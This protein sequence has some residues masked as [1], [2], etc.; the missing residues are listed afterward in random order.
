MPKNKEK[1]NTE[2]DLAQIPWDSLSPDQKKAMQSAGY[3]PEHMGSK[4]SDIS[5]E[6]RQVL[7]QDAGEV[8]VASTIKQRNET[9][10]YYADL[11]R[12]YDDLG[13]A[14]QDDYDNYVDS[15]LTRTRDYKASNSEIVQSSKDSSSKSIVDVN[16][17]LKYWES[18]KEANANTPGELINDNNTE[19]APANDVNVSE[20][21]P[22]QS[23]TSSAIEHVM[24]AA[25]VVGGKREFAQLP[26]EQR[27]EL[28]GKALA[29]EAERKRRGESVEG[30]YG[31]LNGTNYEA[32]RKNATG[33]DVVLYDA[34]EAAKDAIATPEITAGQT[35]G[36]ELV[37]YADNSKEVD[38]RSKGK[39][40]TLYGKS[41]E[42][43]P[44]D[45]L[46]EQAPQKVEDIFKDRP[47]LLRGVT[48]DRSKY[49][50]E[51]SFKAAQEKLMD[52]IHITDADRDE[53][54]RVK[55]FTRLN[56]MKNSLWMG[57]VM[58]GYYETKF[59]K[60][61]AE[62][63]RND[64]IESQLNAKEWLN[65]DSIK[66]P[67]D[68][69]R[70]VTMKRMILDAS[71]DSVRQ[72]E[73][74]EQLA[75]DSPARQAMLDL[76]KQFAVKGEDGKYM[77]P[78][79]FDE[80]KKRIYAEHADELFGD[81]GDKVAYID[82]YYA[83]AEM[84]RSTAD[85]EEGLAAIEKGFQMYRAKTRNDLNTEAHRTHVERAIEKW[86]HSKFGKFIPPEALAAAA[87]IAGYA[88]SSVVRSKAGQIISFG[89]GSLV[90]GVIGAVREGNAVKSER[91]TLNQQLASGEINTDDKLNQKIG[92]TV[93]QMASAKDM[94]NNAKK[95]IASGDE[96]AMMDALTEMTW[97]QKMGDQF[98]V[99]LI[100]YSSPDD[101]A[102]EGLD[103]ITSRAELIVAL[104]KANPDFDA[105]T[106]NGDITEK[107]GAIKSLNDKNL[108]ESEGL[109][110]H[111]KEI[112]SDIQAKD[113][114]FAKLKAKR[115]AIRGVGTVVSSA[116]I[117]SAV[118]E[119]SNFV[120]DQITP[121]TT[122]APRIV[123]GNKA[124]YDKLTEEQIAEF[125][126]KGATVDAIDKM[127]DKTSTE[128][129]SADQATANNPLFQ[130]TAWLNNN[131]ESFDRNELRGYLQDGKMLYQP[132]GASFTNGIH[133]EE[134]SILNAAQQG[135]IHLKLSPTEATQS[136]PF[137][138]VGKLVDGKI[139]F[140]AEPGSPAAKMLADGSYKFAE[141]TDN[142]GFV[143]ATDIGSGTAGS[144]DIAN[145]VQEKVTE[146]D[147]QFP[148]KT[149]MD[150]AS[151]AK[152]FDHV[153]F[154]MPVW[155][156]RNMHNARR[157]ESEAPSGNAEQSD[158]QPTEVI[159]PAAPE[160]PTTIPGS[161]KID[162]TPEQPT[163]SEGGSNEHASVNYDSTRESADLA[164][165]VRDTYDR[166]RAN[167][168][169][170]ANGEMHTDDFE[171]KGMKVTLEELG[172]DIEDELNRRAWNEGDK[173][174]A[175]S[176]GATKELFDMPDSGSKKLS[177]RGRRELEEFYRDSLVID[178][179]LDGFVDWYN[180]SHSNAE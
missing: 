2:Q 14:D 136:H 55:L 171:Y 75:E 20:V 77:T 60:Q 102:T 18:K 57:G 104:R 95:A 50:E 128:T 69:A 3:Q 81:K 9:A 126:S 97:R 88:T 72:G 172:A 131:T 89:G 144:F 147:V 115:Q 120:I 155:I 19:R 28:Q 154:P 21:K 25:G 173:W 133:I 64:D 42:I 33:Q 85:H 79:E 162:T 153:P 78:E 45:T 107:L 109:P 140:D 152:D 48:I 61:A 137:D 38:I 96:Q 34:N 44:A 62:Q 83:I 54:G 146:Y 130:R 43:E 35:H 41:K 22:Y 4:E 13:K 178:K 74:R 117:G 66:D 122:E 47:D 106:F 149:V 175:D 23:G 76:I 156:R 163:D 71:M 170:P 40:L 68:R 159:P 129:V 132:S 80:A 70:A 53:N 157:P 51:A 84:A 16:E 179:S 113:K 24:S 94:M 127:V 143:Y 125:K 86:E 30:F 99:D 5:P 1:V 87:G 92:E 31:K 121:D 168:S 110:D 46:A 100:S 139:E 151:T 98:H 141:I 180:K 142:N 148:D 32:D 67:M 161:H 138:V 49:I 93:Y 108:L 111:A 164:G 56:K 91:A 8:A 118:R 116:V 124:H 177:P 6:R 169:N 158:N 52:A 27:A 12:H 160:R 39:E 36:K 135:N 114:I 11:Q 145:T 37:S 167:G 10:N 65:L 150:Q 166:M 90:T 58:R 103:L 101:V 63:M 29:L 17:A 7:S 73:S 174:N 105:D 82:N 123:P 134:S 59:R 119:A 15:L 112:I 176:L 165:L 26:S